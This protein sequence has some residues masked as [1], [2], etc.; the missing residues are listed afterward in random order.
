MSDFSIRKPPEPVLPAGSSVPPPGRKIV[1][2]GDKIAFVGDSIT[3]FGNRPDGFI[4]LVMEALEQAGLRNLS[5]LPGGVNGDRS[6]LVLKR[7][8]GILAQ[9]PDLV[10]LQVGVNDVGWGEQG[11]VRLPQ[12]K[13]NIRKMIGLCRNA[14][15]RI[16][17]VT[18]S[19]HSENPEAENNCR[20]SAYCAFLRAEAAGKRLPIADWNREMH[21]VLAEG[22][23]P[24]ESG[25]LLTIDRLHLNGYGNLHLA[26]T[27]LASSGVEQELTD[28]LSAQWRRRPSM[29]PVLNAWYDPAWK[30]SMEDYE[31][32]FRAAHARGLTVEAL[33]KRLVDDHIAGEKKKEVQR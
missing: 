28:R 21:R 7:L 26:R 9:K 4:H 19:M 16:L 17:L 11:G 14:G 12:Y 20:L 27:I 8:P 25:L 30:I 3:N 10:I 5:F 31:I 23:I 13:T 29:A 1:R 2:D 24:G 6:N 32:L 22:K 15:A 33:M 18:P